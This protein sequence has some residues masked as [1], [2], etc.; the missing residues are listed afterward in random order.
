MNYFNAKTLMILLCILQIKAQ[1]TLFIKDTLS[2]TNINDTLFNPGYSEINTNGY[3]YHNKGSF[4]FGGNFIRNAGT[5]T[6]SDNTYPLAAKLIYVG[7]DQIKDTLDLP[8]DTTGIL[9]MRAKSAKDTLYLNSR[10]HSARG[11]RYIKGI[12]Q[13]STAAPI[14]YLLPPGIQRVRFV[15]SSFVQGPAI[16]KF[17]NNALGDTLRYPVGDTIYRPLAIKLHPSADFSTNTPMVSTYYI[18][19]KAPAST[20]TYYQLQTGYWKLNV[21]NGSIDASDSLKFFVS[22]RS[23]DTITG[24]SNFVYRILYS[25]DENGTYNN[26]GPYDTLFKNKVIILVDSNYFREPS[27]YSAITPTTNDDSLF[28]TLAIHKCVIDSIQ[29]LNTA[30][31]YCEGDTLGVIAHVQTENISETNFTWK[32]TRINS[33]SSFATIGSSIGNPHFVPLQVFYGGA[34]PYKIRVIT[35]TGS[36][37]VDSLTKQIPVDT[38]MKLKVKVFLQGRYTSNAM[39]ENS[40]YYTLLKNNFMHTPPGTP[41]IWRIDSMFPGFEPAV[42]SGDSAID[43]IH[44]Y[45]IDAS[46]NIIDST[47]G[48]VM[49]NGSVRD[50]KAGQ[51]SVV[52]FGCNTTINTSSNYKVALL[53]K[54]H[55]PLIKQNVSFNKVLGVGGVTITNFTSTTNLLGTQDINYLWDN[56][57]NV[58]IMAGGNA[59]DLENIDEYIVN[60]F[61]FYKYVVDNGIISNKYV[62]T[63]FN[64]DGV[65]NASDLY[66]VQPNN[67]KLIKAPAGVTLPNIWDYY[68]EY[69][70]GGGP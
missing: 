10:F 8:G 16:W 68:N 19:K 28:L 66:I 53:H 2:L 49:P 39:S 56:A 35:E 34:P 51:Y 64:L 47:M 50:F 55:V 38:A 70:S 31:R 36:C 42:F 5:Y 37:V 59:H 32:F 4:F 26:L 25:F 20:P 27:F 58:V 22:I 62:R 57:N 24:F 30:G 48:W 15:D 60:A 61:D 40:N 9:I 67:D 43:V 18:N 3:V 1:D 63:D 29:I 65:V 6:V 23:T 45:V 12:L 69:N 7:H 17:T 41:D 54:N 13:T 44:V 52:N 11:F 21:E 14:V 33:S 46:N